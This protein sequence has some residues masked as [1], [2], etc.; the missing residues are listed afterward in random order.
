[1]NSYEE[2][3]SQLEL[4]GNLRHIPGDTTG[5]P[6]IDLSSNDYLGLAADK[7]LR[8]SFSSDAMFT[9][10]ASR[11]LSARQSEFSQL[12]DMLRQLYGGRHVLMFNSGYHA[13]TGCISS[14]ASEGTL[15]VADKLV[16]ASIIDGIVLSRAPFERFRHNDVEHLKRIM[17]RRAA[18]FQRVLIVTESVFSMDGDVAPLQEIAEVKR[19]YPNALLYVDE[20]HAFGVLGSQGLGL[21]QHMD[22]VDV[23]MCTLGKAAASMG[24]FVAV[25]QGAV[26]EYLVNKARSFIF[27]TAIPPINCAWSR[28]VIS[29]IITMDA[30]RERLQRLGLLLQK[31]TG[32][33]HSGHIQP[34]VTGSSKS[35]IELSQRLLEIGYKVLPIR[36]P[37]VPPGTERLRFSLSL[38]ITEAQLTAL[39]DADILR[40][41]A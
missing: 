41:Q 33:A 7:A 10:S 3:L 39:I 8:E 29:K 19:A 27:S 22:D 37:T 1:M 16:H 26:R 9:S 12:E 23:I 34:L 18:E 11:L 13:N 32:A 38:E 20:A 28:H 40:R 4:A 14:L 35:A 17:Q 31:A 21:C 6:L 5:K 24:A 15:I 36:T 25:K 30:E 2:T